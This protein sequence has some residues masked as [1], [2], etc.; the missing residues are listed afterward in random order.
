MSGMVIS[1]V[2]MAMVGA[3]IA[4]L[5]AFVALLGTQLKTGSG[6]G[7]NIGDDERV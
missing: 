4:L 7:Q 1:K 2:D 3:G 5:I 6:A